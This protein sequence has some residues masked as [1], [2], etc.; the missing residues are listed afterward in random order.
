ML[1]SVSRTLG[2]IPVHTCC[3]LGTK[4]AV[5]TLT[6]VSASSYFFAV[7]FSFTL[8]IRHVYI[9]SIPTSLDLVHGPLL[10][11]KVIVYMNLCV[12]CAVCVLVQIAI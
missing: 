2:A 9:L 8:C 7:L 6:H 5:R 10:S 11:G 4:C 1:Q 3:T 12:C